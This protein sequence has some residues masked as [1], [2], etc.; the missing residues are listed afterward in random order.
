MIAE[1]L[2]GCSMQFLSTWNSQPI[3]EFLD[4]RT[5]GT[6]IRRDRCNPIGFLHPQ[7]VRIPD[8]NPVCG[9]WSNR[10]QHGDLIDQSSTVAASHLGASES[11]SLKLQ[12]PHQ[13]AMLLLQISHRNFQ[14]ESD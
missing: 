14:S 13:L 5:H 2:N 4:L 9:V 6:K 7:L 12:C 3:I 8:F 11:S 10:C 1:R